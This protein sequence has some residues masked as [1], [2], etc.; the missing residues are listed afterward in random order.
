MRID[1]HYLSLDSIA[2]KKESILSLLSEERKDKAYRH[3][4]EEDI[5]LSL[6]GSYLIEKYTPK[7]ELLYKE[8][9][10][11]FKQG[12][13]F[14]ISHS[15]SL[16]I[17]ASN[18]SPIGIDIELMKAREKDIR[19]IAFRDDETIDNDYDFYRRWC[20][21]ESIAKCLGNGLSIGLKNLPSEVGLN[22]YEDK[23]IYSQI[24]V[25]D[26]YMIALSTMGEEVIEINL[27][28]ER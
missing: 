8:N 27:V 23:E 25:H 14:S 11:P 7:G 12:F 21:K 10:K 24:L 19:R 4:K 15:G 2:R 26:G 13:E 9:G 17:F 3:I 22:H 20:I 16:V 18:S 1:V 6:G 28:E 5:L